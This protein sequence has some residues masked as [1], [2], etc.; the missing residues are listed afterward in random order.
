M[1]YKLLRAGLPSV[2]CLLVLTGCTFKQT[3][4]TARLIQHQAVVD[5]AGLEETEVVEPVKVHI[6]APQKW[7]ALNVRDSRLFVNAQWR[8]PSR[9]TG[10]GVAYVRLPFPL[11]ARM[12]VWFAKREYTSRSGDNSGEV[13]GEWVDDL[14]RPWFEARNSNYHVRGY[15]VTKGFEAW[16]IYSGYK[17]EQPP[18]AAELGVAARSLETIVPTPFAPEVPRRPMASGQRAGNDPS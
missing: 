12:L 8:S 10:V 14:G 18:S 2:V 9:M 7:E 17:R 11:P 1:S 13:L 4:P 5:V 16:I 3:V 6:A 15:C